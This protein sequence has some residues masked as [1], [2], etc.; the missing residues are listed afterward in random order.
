MLC[1]ANSEQNCCI[2]ATVFRPNPTLK[3]QVEMEKR[4]GSGVSKSPDSYLRQP[5]RVLVVD[6]LPPWWSSTRR[7]LCEALENVLALAAALEGP[8]R[9]PLLSVYAVSRQQECLLPFVPVQGNLVRLHSCVEELRSLPGEGCVRRAHTGAQLM[10]QAV[11]D[12]LQQYKQFQR[13]QAKQSNCCVEVTVLTSQPGLSTLRQLELRLRETDLLSLKRLMLVHILHSS[14]DRSRGSPPAD[15]SPTEVAE[16][17][18]F[19]VKAHASPG[20]VGG[21][22]VLT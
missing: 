12:S 4:R 13:H 15:A 20:V 22:F 16:G 8:S 2:T 9:I 11:T 17:H 14:A 6:A 10:G 21:C 19:V 1:L 3:T 5:A 7:V 18:T